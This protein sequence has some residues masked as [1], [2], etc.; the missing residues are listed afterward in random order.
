M[1]SQAN[2]DSEF[3]KN[4]KH[5]IFIG[6]IRDSGPSYAQRQAQ[7]YTESDKFIEFLKISSNCNS[8]PISAQS[9]A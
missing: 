2:I 4:E 9:A 6:A 3:R 1:F 7:L 8:R 5:E